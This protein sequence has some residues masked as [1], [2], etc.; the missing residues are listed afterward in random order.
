MEP[1]RNFRRIVNVKYPGPKLRK[2][3]C[4]KKMEE[5]KD[6]LADAALTN[7]ADIFEE[8]GYDSLSHLLAMGPSDLSDLKRLTKMKT[9]HFV[10]LQSTI[11]V[12]RGPATPST[13]ST[14]S[15]PMSVGPV[16]MGPE[17][18]GPPEMAAAAMGPTGPTGPMGPSV[19]MVPMV[20]IEV[21]PQTLSSLKVTL[22]KTYNNWA[23]ARL[24]SL[25]YSTHL[26]CSIM[27]DNNKSGGNRKVL[28]CRTALSKKKRGDNADGGP[29]CPHYLLWS[30]N[31][32]GDWKLNLKKSNLE[33]KDFCES[34]QL[35]TCDQLV[36]DPEFVRSQNLGK[37]STG[38]E[39]SNLALGTNGRIAGSV[40]EHTA[41]RARNTIKHYNA[42]DY[43]DDWSK[44]NEWGHQFM[45]MNPQSFFHLEKDDEGRSVTMRVLGPIV[46][47]GPIC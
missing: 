2:V 14:P 45:A 43:D 5:I 34:G 30:K 16:E 7:Y 24:A 41:R 8:V 23:Q 3:T 6:L 18:M 39:A 31:K 32:T 9:G 42:N 27:Q 12:W 37:L 38:K 36:H 26:G 15:T 28:R 25:N 11:E 1:D 4:A 29:N 10:R 21:G 47:I 46:C 33:H 13:A 19:P 35:V 44:L 20:P 17:E 40:K 22:R